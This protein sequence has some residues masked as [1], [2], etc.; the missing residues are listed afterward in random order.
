M[1][2]FTDLGRHAGVPEADQEDV[3]VL[4][5]LVT[6]GGVRLFLWGVESD[7]LKV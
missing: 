5:A 3:A 1:N 2:V 7:H 4:V 6:C